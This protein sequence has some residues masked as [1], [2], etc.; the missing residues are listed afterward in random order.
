MSEEET[1]AL[2]EGKAE[3]V[4]EGAMTSRVV[5]APK[6]I[7]SVFKANV[8]SEVGIIP[9]AVTAVSEAVVTPP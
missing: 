4:P 5:V 1:V 6:L 7:K 9:K 2:P 8:V 3:A